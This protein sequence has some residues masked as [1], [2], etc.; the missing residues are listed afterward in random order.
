MIA[1]VV[2]RLQYK[3]RIQL[4]YIAMKRLY[5]ITYL[6]YTL[7]ILNSMDNDMHIYSIHLVKL[8]NNVILYTFIVFDLL[9]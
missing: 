2:S 9:N 8:C 3:A 6:Y 1:V 7:K 4:H 5:F